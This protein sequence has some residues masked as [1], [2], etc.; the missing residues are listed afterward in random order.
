MKKQFLNIAMGLAAMLIVS[1]SFAAGKNST[2]T[3]K[4]YTVHNVIDGHESITAYSKKGKW[5]Y[6]INRYSPDNLDVNIVNKIKTV[7]DKYSI[8]G[9][10][11]IEQPGM[12]TVYVAYLEDATSLKTI[13][14]AND[15]M[16]LVQEF[17]K[18]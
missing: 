2:T 6:T 17:S 3:E 13:R 18:G 7:Y 16:E 15:E 10:Q 11:K 8:N 12:E 1:T 9:I 14:I 4:S 5:I